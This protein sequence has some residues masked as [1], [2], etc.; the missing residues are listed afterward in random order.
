[1][2]DP[3]LL[4]NAIAD[5][6]SNLDLPEHLDWRH[7]RPAGLSSDHAPWLAV[8]VS[9]ITHEAIAVDGTEIVYRDVH[10]V[11]V[12]WAESA[13][14]LETLTDGVLETTSDVVAAGTALRQRLATYAVAVPGLTNQL[15]G[16]LVDTVHDSDGATHQATIQL[17]L[18]EIA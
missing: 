14:G 10:Q 4:A 2:I 5:D 9:R 3:T 16:T 1:M 13:E 7:T 12:Q 17:T 8:W 11:T 15:E 6:L 18:A